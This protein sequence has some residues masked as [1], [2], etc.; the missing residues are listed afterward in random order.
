MNMRKIIAVLSAA[1]LLCAAIPMGA[2]TVVAAPGDVIIDADFND[3]MD[4]FNNHSVI[5]GALVIDG[6]SADWANSFIY[7]G[8]K[9]GVKYQVTFS[10]KADA[11]QSL[12]F[13]INNGWA[14][15]NVSANAALTTEY[16]EY[17]LFLTPDANLVEP[18]FTIQT[19]TEAPNGTI[20]YIDWVKV[21]E[22]KEPA[23]PGKI[24][25]GDFETGDATG[26]N[27][28]QQGGVSAEAA[29][30]GSYGVNI[31][32]GGSYGGMLDQTIPAEAGKSYEIS[33]WLK[34]NATGVN[35]Q[36]K[37]GDT[38][39]ADIASEWFDMNK[40]GEWTQFTYIVTPTTDLLTINFCGAGNNNAEDAYVDSVVVT[41]KKGVWSIDFN[42]GTNSFSSS[43]LVAEGPDGTNCLKWSAT[44]GWSSTWTYA[45]VFKANTDYTVTFKAKAS[46]AGG[47]GITIEDGGWGNYT[48]VPGGF[49]V[50]TE[51]A[52]YAVTFNTAN[53]PT[54]NGTILF[55]FQDVGVAMD[56]YV[57]DIVI[58]EG[59]PEQPE[60]P[61]Q[62]T[63]DLIAN[64]DFEDGK[65]NWTNLWGSSTVEIVEGR[66]GGSALKGTGN[67]AYHIVYQEVAV[68]PNT[69]YTVSAY[70]KNAV[71]ADL[72]IKSEGGAA[73]I[74]NTAFNSGSDWAV[75][76]I[77]FNSGDNHSVWVG[78]MAL[79]AGS[80]YI[81]D[82]ITMAVAELTYLV[83]GDFETGVVSPWVNLWGDCP[84]VEIVEGM[85][86]GYGLHIVSGQYLHVRQTGI[87]V[88][89]N[90]DYKITLWAKNSKNM[91]VLVKDGADAVDIINKG[92]NAGEEWT[93]FTFFFNS[94][95]YST[96]IVSLMGNDAE[97]YGTFDNVVMEKPDHVC[98]YVLDNENSTFPTCDEG[99]TAIYACSTCGDSY[100]EDLPAYHN[101][102]MEYNPA[103]EAID[104]ANPGNIENYY[105]PGCNEYFAD[106]YAQEIINPWYIEVTVDCVKPE[107]LADCAGWTCETCGNENFG[108]GEHDVLICQGGTCSKCNAEIEGVGCQN[109]DT[110]A[111]E[112]GV[113]HY[114]GGFVAGFGHENGAWAPCC[115]GE[116]AYGCGL[117][118][119]AT[120]DHVDAGGDDY[121]DNCWN[122]LACIDADAD[123]F[124]DVCWSEMPAAEIV[125]GDA[126]GDGA[127]NNIDVALLQQYIAGYDVTLEE[128][129]ADANGDG[130][131]N[132]IDV[133]LLQQ[134]IAGYDVTLG[135]V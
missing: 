102:G 51:W 11:P 94:G 19:N 2:L 22:Y 123:G 1:L 104:C 75:T 119:P 97:A 114:C 73:N 53:H 84:T 93:K 37:D 72:W 116:C 46:V 117:I 101:G 110:P 88:N 48:N 124:C 99:G 65:N 113:C 120:E 62:P 34:V 49:N 126:N 127:V 83:N 131:V 32:G 109:L 106:A 98:D 45:K 59:L 69:Y 111:C 71:G 15:T 118:Y 68:T 52:D 86:G 115:D 128:V 87:A 96:V 103:K 122:H 35:F 57:D 95:D 77:T 42:D 41:E 17:E 10:A 100:T 89:P 63:G 129:S 67:G 33:F 36:I 21:V 85:D 38:S 44:G 130:A 82:D 132:N 14:G 105:C 23:V 5:D 13:K 133:A 9:P 24:V 61:E 55:K 20:F 26:W 25:N 58:A 8:F 4:G 76:S 121:C 43:A 16:A 135:P 81:V 108:A 56:L 30:D 78:L 27:L 60:Q 80:T 29:H 3:G 54:A 90:T 125:Y 12:G 70:S 7:A 66:N 79:N 74:A 6:T 31:K 107:G 112:D 64:G 134:Y 91:S 28:P 50:T 92:V 18:I 47:M 39:G 40:A